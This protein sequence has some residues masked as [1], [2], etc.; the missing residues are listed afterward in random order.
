M[1]ASDNFFQKAEQAF[2]KK[3]YDYAIALYQ[4]GLAI[5]PDRVDERRKLRAAAIRKVQEGGGSTTGGRMLKM[6]M[7]GPFTSIKKLGMQKKFEEQIVEI[8]KILAVAPQHAESLMILAAAFQATNRLDSARQSYQE[9]VEIEPANTDAWKSLGRLYEGQ[10]ELD[11]A[12]QCWERVKQLT[13]E[14]AEAGKAIRDL[15]AAVMMQRTDARKAQSKDD[16]FKALLKDEDES[17]KLQKK[18]QLIRTSDDAQIALQ[19][20]RDEIAKTP[21][22]SRLWRELGD[23]HA[24]VRQFDE[25]EKAF[26]KALEVNPQDMYAAENIARLTEQRIHAGIED[27]KIALTQRPDDA[28]VKATLERLLSEQN[29]FLLGEYARRVAA[30]PTDF[31][32]KFEFGEVLLRNGR[33]DEAIGQFQNARKDPKFATQ[34]HHRIGKAFHSKGLFDLAVRELTNSLSGITDRDTTLWKTVQYDLAEAYEAKGEKPKALEL[35]EEIMSVDINFRD[36]SKRVDALR[37]S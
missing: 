16:S 19:I 23:L 6:K 33:F 2:K 34:S 1:G 5:D 8:E 13:P 26:R 30:H 11:K 4:Q 9:A 27:A 12:V 36:V 15:S 25:A 22:N 10:K 37:K 21:T 31:K 29:E 3:N 7:L 35:F 17:E 24:K 32:L 14:D 18:G 28:A 20:K